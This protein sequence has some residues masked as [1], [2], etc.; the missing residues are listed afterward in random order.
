ME[1]KFGPHTLAFEEP[2]LVKFTFQG[3]LEESDQQEM[4]AFVEGL[5][6]RQPRLF[7]LGD[8]RHGT[9]FSSKSR[10]SLG[11]KPRPVPYQAMAFFGASFTLRTLFNMLGRAHVLLNIST[12]NMRFTDTEEEA[13]EW[14]AEQRAQLPTA[15]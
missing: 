4:I 14:L 3:Q 10:R 13:R 7:L 11:E 5:R 8:L 2:D 6:A 15:P 9:G 1:W 12:V